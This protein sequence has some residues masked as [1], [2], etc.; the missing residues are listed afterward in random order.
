MVMLLQDFKINANYHVLNAN[1]TVVMVIKCLLIEIAKI[2]KVIH[3]FLETEELS[4]NIL[5]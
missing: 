2:S 5:I 3:Y 1:I 4:T